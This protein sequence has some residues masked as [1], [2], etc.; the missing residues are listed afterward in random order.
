MPNRKCTHEVIH[1]LSDFQQSSV[2][3][4][5]INLS[6][7]VYE[8]KQPFKTSKHLVQQIFLSPL[9]LT[10]LH[11]YLCRGSRCPNPCLKA[12]FGIFW[13]PKTTCG[14]F[15]VSMI[16]ITTTLY[17]SPVISYYSSLQQTF[18]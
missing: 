10:Q 17:L 9:N 1:P 15:P 6:Q 2:S 14:S 5:Q 11:N 16:S 7:A 12:P 8:D 3:T 4:I 18:V 13:L